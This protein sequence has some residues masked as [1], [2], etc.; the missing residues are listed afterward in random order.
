MCVPRQPGPNT[1]LAPF[2]SVT[3]PGVALSTS[4]VC[5][6]LLTFADEVSYGRLA[7]IMVGGLSRQTEKGHSLPLN[8]Q[9]LPVKA[10]CSDCRIW[11]GRNLGL[12]EKISK[13]REFGLAGG[14]EQRRFD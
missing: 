2:H 13:Q 6:P 11:Q 1:N 14:A 7:S 9:E 3:A 4:G 5:S 12:Y 10:Y 8:L